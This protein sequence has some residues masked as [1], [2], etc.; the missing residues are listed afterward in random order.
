MLENQKVGTRVALGF[1]VVVVMLAALGGVSWHEAAESRDAVGELADQAIVAELVSRADGSVL[2]ARLGSVRYIYAGGEANAKTIPAELATAR[3]ELTQARALMKQEA[4][5]TR[6]DQI[7]A[8]LD[9][10]ERTSA[11][12]AIAREQREATNKDV[13]Y[14]LG[15]KLRGLMVEMRDAE[16]AAGHLAA[17]T[18]VTRLAEDVW[19]ARI[20]VFRILDGDT[21]FDFAA[22]RKRVDGAAAT[23]KDL[24]D[25]T[26]AEGQT[27]RIAAAGAMLRDFS[28]G[29]SVL[30]KAIATVDQIRDKRLAPIGRATAD[31]LKE[32]REAATARQGEMR[33]AAIATSGFA[34]TVAKTLTPVAVLLA[35]LLAWAI[36]RGVSRPVVAMTGAM[37]RLAQ[38]DTAVEVP[39]A[40]R[41]DEIGQMAVAVQVFKDNLI[42]NRAME[43]EVKR[44]QRAAEEEKRAAMRRLADSFE[45]S[46]KGVVAQVSSAASQ[47]QANSRR[48]TE[49]AE[50]G[51]ERAGTVMQAAELASANVQTVAASAEEMTSSIS[52]IS[53]QVN[54]S[55]EVARRA[56]QRADDTTRSVQALAEQARSIGD[57]VELINS[58][59]AQTNLLA[60]NA[61]IEAARAG[62]A[63]KGFA[64]VASEVKSLATQ[65]AKATEEIAGQITGM[66]DAT[67]GAVGAIG[68]IAAVIAQINEIATTIAAAVEEQ[69]AATREIARS[70]QQAAQGTE[71]IS[72]NIGGV[73]QIADGT[74]S[75]AHE[76][77]GA[78]DTLFRDSE[79][80]SQDVDRFIAEVRAS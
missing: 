55:S 12:I 47:M 9:D 52:E 6:V 26:L 51:R 74:G 5:R 24:A 63:G 8:M 19:T 30:E 4:N 23:F 31:K 44:A 21:A 22:V 18:A 69:D 20:L 56:S 45:A 14:E 60:L 59:A 33:A 65:T 42:R 54:Q 67:R 49:M 11:E 29:L 77:L 35:C 80:L 13:I 1:G 58:I 25:L 43:E 78:A 50:D 61:T 38:G 41:R 79:R 46:I 57:V 2:R 72:R 16:V 53:R 40:G 64:V 68:E 76:A 37:E 48:L 36:G 66:Q 34:E 27:E 39:A 62:E 7:L 15:S 70:V 17:A 73:Q 32:A 75:A 3:G 28:N 10:Y 71:E